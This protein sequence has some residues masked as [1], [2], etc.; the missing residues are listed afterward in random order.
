MQLLLLIGI[1]TPE[2]CFLMNMRHRWLAF[3]HLL[4]GTA[5]FWPLITVGRGLGKIMWFILPLYFDKGTEEI[6]HC[7][8]ILTTGHYQHQ[9]S[10]LHKASQELVISWWFSFVHT[11]YHW[12][13]QTPFRLTQVFT[14]LTLDIICVITKTVLYHLCMSKVYGGIT[15]EEEEGKE[16]SWNKSCWQLVQKGLK[17]SPVW[18]VNF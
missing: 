5:V 9:Q 4:K 12:A 14:C 8:R 16:S 3:P 15:R 7:H 11:A 18:C 6:E 1:L 13:L 17:Y 10:A 2:S